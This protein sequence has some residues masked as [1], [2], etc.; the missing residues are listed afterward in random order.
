VAQVEQAAHRVLIV[1]GGFA[2]LYAARQLGKDERLAITVVDRRNFHLFTPLLYQVATGAVSPGDIAQPLRSILRRQRNTTVLLGE[3]VGLD[4]DRREVLLADG[5]PL[6]YDSLIVASGARFSYFGHDG[7][8][9]DA[10]G[11]KSLDDALEI[12]RRILI[13]FEAAEREHDPQRRAEWLTF[14]IVGGGPTGVELAGS[15][16]EIARDTLRRDFRSIDTRS[17]RINLVEALPRILPTYPADRSASARRQLERLGATV[18]TATRVVDIDDHSV[19]V[20]RAD[21]TRELIPA[22]TV[23]WAAGILASSFVSAVAKATAA[24]TDRNGRIEVQPDLTV[25]GHP[26]IFA[27]GDAAVQPWKKDRAVPGVAQGGIQG[28]RYA[29]SLIQARLSAE[30]LPPF[31]YRNR[32]DVAV[33]GR[34]A[35]VTDIPWLGPFGRQSGFP[36]WVLWLTIHILYLIGFANRI[37]VVVRWAWSFFTRGRGSRL[38]TGAPLL[39]PIEEPEP[40]A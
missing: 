14:V 12:R 33:I 20:E 8:A 5:G 31:R 15:L 9:R 25:P 40:P 27:V 28:G 21:G 29:A 19:T 38:I 39:P 24:P 22:R 17:A 23:L 1:G 30:T 10:P 26:E 2:G 13:A 4:P 36:A 32:G 3:A 18:R 7:W 16:G 11:L 35:G 34:L 6:G 37:V